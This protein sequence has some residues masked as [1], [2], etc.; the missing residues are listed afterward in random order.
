MP[1]TSLGDPLASARARLHP[2]GAGDLR[3]Q[4]RLQAAA[5]GIHTVCSGQ[6]RMM[7]ARKEQR[8]CQRSC[9]RRCAAHFPALSQTLRLGGT[10]HSN[11]GC[12]LWV[13][14]KGCPFAK[15]RQHAPQLRTQTSTPSMRVHKEPQ[16]RTP[17]SCGHRRSLRVVSWALKMVPSLP[18]RVLKYGPLIGIGYIIEGVPFQGPKQR[19]HGTTLS[20]RVGHQGKRQTCLPCLGW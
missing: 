11:T 16:R 4:V 2:G 5:P 3:L 20:R 1:C 15:S 7:K 6:C 10:L 19:D 8:R 9:Q 14:L 13:R 18:S 17:S 12:E